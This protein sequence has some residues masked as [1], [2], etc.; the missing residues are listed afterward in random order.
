MNRFLKK[1]VDFTRT[2]S[3]EILTG[4]EL[5]GLGATAYFSAKGGEKSSKTEK[6]SEKVKAYLPAIG[7]GTATAA[8][9]IANGMI[10]KRQKTALIGAC[11]ALE[12]QYNSFRKS[13]DAVTVSK[14]DTKMEEES[15]K[16]SPLYENDTLRCEGD[17]KLTWFDPCTSTWFE[18]S[19]NDLLY[20]RGEME[21]LMNVNG[22]VTVADFYKAIGIP[23]IEKRFDIT[24]WN[25]NEIYDGGWEDAGFD[26][27]IY[28]VF[29]DPD[30][31]CPEHYE[32]DYYWPPSVKAIMSY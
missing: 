13:V 8:T 31:E 32:I 11:V 15:F 26:F 10:N 21:R 3:N 28:H 12:H 14:A 30:F 20:A 2:H 24:G 22:A 5:V 19:K 1:A 25:V 27:R 17:K 4:L 9:I 16:E 23:H 29:D 7:V 18:A 6:R